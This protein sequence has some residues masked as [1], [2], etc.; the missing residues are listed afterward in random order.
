MKSRFL[1]APQTSEDIHPPKGESYC[2]ACDRLKENCVCKTAAAKSYGKPKV[3]ISQPGIQHGTPNDPLPGTDAENAIPPAPKRTIPPDLPNAEMRV[4]KDG[5]AEDDTDVYAAIEQ[6][7]WVLDWDSYDNSDHLDMVA[8][9]PAHPDQQLYLYFGNGVN[10]QFSWAIQD[11]TGTNSPDIAG[12]EDEASLLQYL[13]STTMKSSS[14]T[15][16]NAVEGNMAT[17]KKSSREVLREKIA[18]RRKAQAEEAKAKFA[19]LRQVAMDEPKEVDAAL[20]ELGEALGTMADALT[21]LKENLD[22]VQ[23]PK[24]AALK[25]RIASARKYASSFRRMAEEAPE[26]VADALNEVYNS[27]DEIAAGVENLAENLGVELHGSEV[28]KEFA[29]EGKEELAEAKEEGETVEEQIHEEAEGTEG[30][31]E[32]EA[33]DAEQREEMEEEESEEVPEK[34]DEHEASGNDWF[35]TDRDEQG[36]PKEAAAGSDM[37]VTDRDNGGAPKAPEKVDR[38][39]TQVKI[40]S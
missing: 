22:L 2:D 21:N 37:F 39:D 34:F 19:R 20:S 1:A 14:R 7:G 11:L 35:V 32:D 36:E 31:P 26:V 29:E 5:A 40:T 28:M 4:W 3:D 15:A 6:H 30:T 17:E 27:L 33:E 16:K 24:E 25:V 38:S 10:S 8:S 18:A 23:A 13:N 12:G 9:N